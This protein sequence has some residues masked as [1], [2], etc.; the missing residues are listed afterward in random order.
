M[1]RDTENR[2]AYDPALDAVRIAPAA[3]G[4]LGALDDAAVTDP[5]AASASAASLLRGILTE[6]QAHTALLT[7]IAANTGTP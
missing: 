6:L 7:T 2:G 5:D 1:A 3:G 4:V